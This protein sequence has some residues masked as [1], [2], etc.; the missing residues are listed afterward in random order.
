[1]NIANS[2]TPSPFFFP[3]I[4]FG[5]PRCLDLGIITSHSRKGNCRDK[6][7]IDLFFSHFK[8]KMFYFNNFKAEEEELIQVIE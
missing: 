7:C 5:I 6:A 1:M 8:S 4:P 3:L 2:C